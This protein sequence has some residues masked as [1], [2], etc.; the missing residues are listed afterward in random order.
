MKFWIYW[1]ICF[2][3]VNPLTAQQFGKISGSVIDK[4]NKEKIA[5]AHVKLNPELV[6]SNT[7]T[8]GNFTLD[9]IPLGF[10]EL[11]IQAENYENLVLDYIRIIPNKT[12]S[13][14]IELTAKTEKMS[15]IAINKRQ[16]N[17]ITSVP[18][19]VHTFSREEI[20]MNPGAQGDIFR[21]IGMLPGVS[22]SG[23]IYSA[24]SV[25]GQGV[26]DN[27]Y[28]VD[29][30]PVT[31]VGHLEGNSFFNDPNGGRFSIFAPRVIEKA[32]FQGGGYSSEFG[33][34][35]ASLLALQ[36]QEGNRK[37]LIVD[38]QMD[39]LGLT[40][41][42]DGPVK[43]LK[44]TQYFLSV[45]Y[46][47]FLGLVN[48]VGLKDIGLPRYADMIAKTV[49]QK[50]NHKITTLLIISPERYTRDI[51][52]ARADKNLN[53]MYLPDFYRNKTIAGITVKSRLT[54][55]VDLKNIV[56]FTDYFSDIN[57]GKAI[58]FTDST[59]K[60]TH[61]L[62][63]VLSKLQVQNYYEQKLGFRSLLTVT[64]NAKSTLLIGIE[65]DN[66]RIFN[67]RRQNYLDTQYIY[68]QGQNIPGQN[69]LII[70]PKFVNSD[71]NASAR[72]FSSYINFNQKI[73]NRLTLNFGLR[74]DYNGFSNQHCL[75]PRVNSSFSFP[76]SQTI[77]FAWGIYWQDPV[78]SDIADQGLTSPLTMEKTTHYILAYHKSFANAGRFILEAWYKDFMHL[79]TRPIP[80]YVYQINTG[81][82]FGYGIDLNYS[83]KLTKSFSGQL[84]Y[85]YMQSKRRN[86]SGESLY[87]FAF[88]QPNQVN[89]LFNYK[90]N[91]KFI[92]SIKYRYATGKPSDQFITHSNVLNT[93]DYYR[94]SKEITGIN[95]Q[96][97]PNFNSLDIRINYSFY[98][99]KIN[100][101]AFF[102]AV[103][104]RNKQIPNF[105]NFNS[106]SGKT[107]FDGLAIFP[108][109]GMK[110]EF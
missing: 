81:S 70:D 13:Y 64:L 57:V 17:S 49:T 41:N 67:R 65:G 44:N 108:T 76:K 15:V 29:D 42:F 46:Q 96:R 61:P 79:I 97:L 102:D 105:E 11:L 32:T 35:S 4:S 24:I 82:G 36:V 73:G 58:P 56:Y 40:L 21:A 19:S 22:S 75:G 100:I 107:Y 89:V 28:L 31:E 10:H 9:S 72:N 103:N 25:R 55:R 60:L 14:T 78:F 53:L 86:S 7:D 43:Q 30:I 5:F 16:S 83:K 38:G 54:N 50:K 93:S 34:R 47:N 3:V 63:T 99:K 26:R 94:Y 6:V 68:Y 2:I 84:G 51:N 59:G 8:L 69:Y 52:H 101:T 1:A 39:L 98:W 37:N 110:F 48:V 109:G 88:D 80:G 33:R 92:A 62:N 91:A 27:V 90:F 77:H 45:R 87:P 23:G 71:F 66:T 12:L 104:V 18:I 74:H 95:L 85:S 20:S 106:F